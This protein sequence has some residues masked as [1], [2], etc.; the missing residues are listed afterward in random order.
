MAEITTA[1]RKSCPWL[2]KCGACRTIGSKYG[3]TLRAKEKY[4]RNLLRPYVQLTD[5]V[6][7][8]DPYCYRNKVHRVI[9]YE[10]EGRKERRVSGIYAEGTHKLVPVRDCLIED[11]DASR[12]ISG[13]NEIAASF[14][15]TAYSEDTGA[16][17]LRHIL[18]RY[19]RATGE[20]M[21]V[22]VLTSPVLPGKKNFA[23]VVRE[24]FPEITTLILNVNSRETSLILGERSSVIYGKGYIEDVLCGMRFRI[25]PGSFY[26][27][28]P[29]QTEKL[30]TQAVEWANLTGRETVI[31]AYCGIGTIGLT[32]SKRAKQVIGIEVNRAAALD[33]GR[34]A[35]LNQ[36][37][38]C[39]F[40]EGDA[41][42]YLLKMAAE[43]RKADVVFMDPPRSGS[44]EA[45]M[46]AAAAV[47]PGRIIYISCNPETLARDL[48]WLTSHGYRAKEARAYDM[49]PWT[50]SVESIVLLTRKSSR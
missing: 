42:E 50:D 2:K 32:A 36:A 11:R 35:K 24:R 30:Y 31:D 16:G 20:I 40:L 45:F 44:T 47:S 48:K 37:G 18:V 10:R 5:I 4:V 41:G 3:D 33:A 39:L 38:N 26:Q 7:M 19:A 13:I 15:I 1:G 34:N 46:E 23:R 43:R 9:S 14:K 12:I 28:N 49:F 17:L 22:L 25:S 8:E 27:I 29:V 21:A 6:G